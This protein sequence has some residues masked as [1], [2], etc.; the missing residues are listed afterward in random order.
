MIGRSPIDFRHNRCASRFLIFC[1]SCDRF[2]AFRAFPPGTA[3]LIV[4]IDGRHAAVG[5]EIEELHALLTRL[6]ASFIER[7]P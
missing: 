7:A 4:E 5:S 1:V 2:R 3:R 6:G